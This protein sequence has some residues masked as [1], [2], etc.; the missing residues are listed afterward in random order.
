MEWNSPGPLRMASSSPDSLGLRRAVFNLSRNLTV[1]SGII[2][3]PPLGSGNGKIVFN[4]TG[5]QSVSTSAT[6]TSF[7][8]NLDYIRSNL[9]Q[10]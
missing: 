7:Q 2:I 8:G 6:G 3:A 5:I 4:G 10:R 9:L 1:R